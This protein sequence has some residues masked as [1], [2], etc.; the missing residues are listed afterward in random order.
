MVTNSARKANW[1]LG[2]LRTWWPTNQQE[3]KL[4]PHNSV[5]FLP[6]QFSLC[7]RLLGNENTYNCW[8]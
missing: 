6:S 7:P 5:Q 1:V 2:G 3:M 8:K 4:S